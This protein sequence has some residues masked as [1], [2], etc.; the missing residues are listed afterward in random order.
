MA[1]YLID[2][3]CC[4]VF[5]ASPRNLSLQSCFPLFHQYET[6]YGSVIRGFLRDK[7]GTQKIVNKFGEVLVIVL[8]TKA[9]MYRFI[10]SVCFIFVAPLDP[11]VSPV[12][13]QCLSENWA[14]ISLKNGLQSLPDTLYKQISEKGVQ[15]FMQQP[16]TRL[17]FENGK[18]KVHCTCMWL[19]FCTK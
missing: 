12:V 1:N 2:P 4:G 18:F 17:T 7:E 10:R 3:L 8:S 11:S 15:V 13:K 9:P 16:C 14:T 19:I 5:A 6:K